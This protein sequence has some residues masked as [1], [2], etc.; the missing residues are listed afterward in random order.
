LP[1]FYH[2]KPCQYVPSTNRSLWPA[3][4]KES[5]NDSL[6]DE[7]DQL[8]FIAFLDRLGLRPWK[9]VE[10]YV[11]YRFRRMTDRSSFLAID[12]KENVCFHVFMGT[13]N[14]YAHT[15][16]AWLIKNRSACCMSVLAFAHQYFREDSKTIALHRSSYELIGPSVR[17]QTTSPIAQ[18]S[19]II[20]AA[21]G[22]QHPS[23]S[24][25]PTA[26]GI[27]ET[28]LGAERSSPCP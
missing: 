27:P 19:A 4:R 14:I 3:F 17:I 9:K 1:P 8:D 18:S 16:Y 23:K 28:F 6:Y 20:Q 26:I 15:D 12:T 21:A 5:A 10:H 25:L 11:L 24:G 13:G 7:I 2:I 22:D